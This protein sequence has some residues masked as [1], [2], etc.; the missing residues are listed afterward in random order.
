MFLF[1]D[2]AKLCEGIPYVTDSIL[3][4][5]DLHNLQVWSLGNHLQ[6]N[7]SKYVSLSY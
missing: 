5:R 7:I 1:A 4:Q 2:D 6:F 3:L